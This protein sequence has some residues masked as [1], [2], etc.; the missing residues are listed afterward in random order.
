MGSDGMRVAVARERQIGQPG[1]IRLLDAR[2]GRELRSIPANRQFSSRIVVSPDGTWIASKSQ[3]R[4]LVIW[5][6]RSGAEH[7]RIPGDQ[8]GPR[9]VTFSR[10]GR[11]LAWLESPAGIAGQ[12]PSAIKVWILA[13]KRAADD[14]DLI[15]CSSL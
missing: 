8:N 9:A 1:D 3:D 11:L 6:A 13:E 15:V 7:L 5:D 2:D 12:G 10:D 4:S 14:P